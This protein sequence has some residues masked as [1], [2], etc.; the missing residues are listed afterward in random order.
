MKKRAI[1][2][3]LCFVLV[4]SVCSIVAYADTSDMG[5]KVTGTAKIKG[6][7]VNFR[8]GP[9]TGYSSGGYVHTDETGD[10]TNVYPGFYNREWY[11]LKMTSGDHDG[12]C[13]WVY[14]PYVIAYNINYA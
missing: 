9:G 4:V 2:L 13:G 8:S 14:Y 11:R 3:L 7:G 12:E 5:T 10:V 6:D 1:S